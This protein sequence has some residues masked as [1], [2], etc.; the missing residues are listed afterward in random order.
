[1]GVSSNTSTSRA[2]RGEVTRLDI[3]RL[4]NGAKVAFG[5]HTNKA[6]RAD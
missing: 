4:V 1:M 5:N 6:E 2:V 3:K